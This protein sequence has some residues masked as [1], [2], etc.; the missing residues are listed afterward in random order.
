MP[1]EVG[2]CESVYPKALGNAMLLSGLWVGD[3]GFWGLF[4]LKLG[5]RLEE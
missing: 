5:W 1:S 2:L 3:Y 4:I